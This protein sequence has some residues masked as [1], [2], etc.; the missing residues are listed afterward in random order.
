MAP[1]L[2]EI[3][4]YNSYTGIEKTYCIP[5]QL[6]MTNKILM[7]YLY[8]SF[9][10]ILIAKYSVAQNWY[11]HGSEW[12]FDNIELLDYEAHGYE[13][14]V[15]IK[16]TLISDS[17]SKLIFHK[18]YHFATGDL[19][20]NDSLIIYENKGE[21]YLRHDSSFKLMYNFNLDAKDTLSVKV[22]QYPICDS[23]SPI[24]VD[25]VKTIELPENI[26]DVQYL[27]YNY[28]VEGKKETKTDSIIEQIGNIQSF[29]YQ[30]TC[31]SESW[32]NNILRCFINNDI[33]FKTN[34][35][36]NQYPNAPCDTLIDESAD[37]NNIVFDDPLRLYPNPAIDYIEVYS[38]NIPITEV[39][40]YDI[41]G[42]LIQ[43]KKLASK[44]VK[45]YLN[46]LPGN[47][48]YIIRVS[49]MESNSVEKLIKIK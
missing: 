23:V 6:E 45:L 31:G 28:Y 21:V 9:I 16:D 42:N 20:K 11:Q 48:I 2:I 44:K 18:K 35:W 4:K 41:N 43:N 36:L 33:F 7:K 5:I 34:W 47:G 39:S 49:N 32:N 8:I 17:L 12:Y 13:T 10:L 25:S 3:L 24:T 14:Y 19:I 26:F 30:P 29:I 46:K 15:V 27:S 40:I 22:V 1:H 37:I 38:A